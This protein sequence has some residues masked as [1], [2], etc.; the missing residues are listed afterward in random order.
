MSHW[1]IS[2]WAITLAAAGLPLYIHFPHFATMQ[3]GLSLGWVGVMLTVLRIVDMA[4][5]PLLGWLAQRGPFSQNT[6]ARAVA[7]GLGTGGFMLFAAPSLIL[8]LTG[9]ALSYPHLWSVIWLTVTFSAYSLG[10]ILLYGQTQNWSGQTD[11]KGQF[12]VAKYREL[13]MLIGVVVLAITPSLASISVGPALGYAA[14]G[15]VI[16]ALSVAAVIC[17]RGLWHERD[18]PQISAPH[19]SWRDTL[20][21]GTIPLLGLAW[22]NSLPVA[23]T[24]TT[25]VFFVEDYL[26]LDMLSG[27]L[28]IVFFISSALGVPVW[29]ALARRIGTRATLMCAMGLA[30]VCLSFTLTL[31]Q[32]DLWAYVVVCLTTGFAIG[33]DLVLLPSL[34]TAHLARHALPQSQAFGLWSF[35]SKLALVGAAL[36]ALPILDWVAFSSGTDNSDTARSALLWLY[37]GV[38]AGLKLLSFLWVAALP[39]SVFHEQPAA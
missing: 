20:R 23:M 28:L 34:F 5:D 31:D 8:T 37:A 32:G 17:Q 18:T 29:T 14:V 21:H 12:N 30:L 38:P 7:L 26:E 6:L 15:I 24:S 13:G 10:M 2:L 11:I 35:A 4:Q 1:K 16:A 33:A 25:F 22:V 9:S 19:T 36:I 27:P 39:R 3:L